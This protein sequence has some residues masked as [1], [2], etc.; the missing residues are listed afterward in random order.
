M[1]H[2]LIPSIIIEWQYGYAVIQLVAEAVYCII[3][4]HYIIE[5]PVLNNP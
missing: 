3:N 5:I 2:L 4:N 1:E